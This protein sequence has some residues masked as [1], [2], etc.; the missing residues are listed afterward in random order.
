MVFCTEIRGKPLWHSDFLVRPGDLTSRKLLPALF[1]LFIKEYIP[2]QFYI[3]GCARS[4]LDDKKIPAECKGG[5]F[6][7]KS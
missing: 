2:P 4:S 7:E 3:L 5:Y 6:G 1:N